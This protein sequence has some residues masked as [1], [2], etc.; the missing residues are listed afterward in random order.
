MRRRFASGLRDS[1]PRPHR[2]GDVV[3]DAEENSVTAKPLCCGFR[4]CCVAATCRLWLYF[5]GA[6]AEA[7]A[8]ADWTI[9]SDAAP[10]ASVAAMRAKVFDIG[11]SM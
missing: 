4:T 10:I 9:N 6:L 3:F 1:G 5:D 11:T 8:A 2:F 7:P